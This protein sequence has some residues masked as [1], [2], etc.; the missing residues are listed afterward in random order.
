MAEVEDMRKAIDWIKNILASIPESIRE[1]TIEKSERVE[2][3]ELLASRFEE[4]Q[5]FDGN[6]INNVLSELKSSLQE[7]V[8]KGKAVKTRDKI[9]NM[10]VLPS[11]WKYWIPT[12]E[13]NLFTNISF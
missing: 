5:Q 10:I 6:K 2:D 3:L 4:K 8:F 7:A 12:E 13:D 9:V 1:N 11:G